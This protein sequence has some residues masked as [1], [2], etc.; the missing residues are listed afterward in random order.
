M[1]YVGA[2]MAVWLLALGAAQDDSPQAA[3]VRHVVSVFQPQL[4]MK[5]GN[6]INVTELKADGA[7]AVWTI[8]IPPRVSSAYEVEKIQ[9]QVADAFCRASLSNLFRQGVASR[10]DLKINGKLI[11][12][13][14]GRC[15]AAA[16]PRVAEQKQ[17]TRDLEAA[18]REATI[19]AAQQ[20]EAERIRKEAQQKEKI[21]EWK[22]K[23]RQR[24]FIDIGKSVRLTTSNGEFYD[25]RYIYTF[26][27]NV[28]AGERIFISVTPQ[29]GESG[30][31]SRI[32]SFTHI[33][34]R[35]DVKN[36]NSR[37][38]QQDGSYDIVSTGEHAV[39][40]SVATRLYLQTVP[41][42]THVLRVSRQ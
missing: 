9:A 41:F 31:F 14:V 29:D 37:G 26:R 24:P 22:A 38:R 19:R 12:G 15:S 42:E 18:K 6:G 1:N 33:E 30:A 7:Y 32:E 8:E 16:A 36:R 27:V 39:I 10:V 23:V 35:T 11:R 20:A 4:P 13:S 25:G 34:S 17:I 21:A 28:R 2:T 3:A 40:A 5:I